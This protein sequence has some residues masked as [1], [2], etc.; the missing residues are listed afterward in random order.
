MLSD[1]RNTKAAHRFLGKALKIM[2]DWPP[3]SI[4]TD[5]LG[6]YPKAIRRR[7]REGVLAGAVEHRTSKYLN[8]MMEA[9]HGAMKP[10][11]RRARGF[12]TMRTASAT[13]KGIETMRMIRRGHCILREPGAKGEVSFV[14]KLFGLAAGKTVVK[15][16]PL[17]LPKLTQR[18]PRPASRQASQHG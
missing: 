17:S 14:G 6:S 11:I 18:C 10:M 3:S 16:G 9:D 2:H 15:V 13:I 12:K 7:K 8:N 4:T 5:R 1:R